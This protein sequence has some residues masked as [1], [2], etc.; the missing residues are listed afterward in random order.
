MHIKAR[1]PSGIYY[2]I[3]TLLGYADDKEGATVTG[4]DI[5]DEPR[6]PHRGLQ[7]DLARNFMP[8][9][10]VMRV[11][12]LMGQYKLN[13]LHLHLANDEGWRIDIPDIPELTQVQSSRFAW[14]KGRVCFAVISGTFHAIN[15]PT[16]SKAESFSEHGWRRYDIKKVT[17]M[18]T[19]TCERYDQTTTRR[20]GCS[21]V[22]SQIYKKQHFIC[23]NLNSAF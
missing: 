13:K 8:K 6:F 3:H 2:G 10:D 5:T 11:L 17:N 18:P 1:D 22:P 16:G 14:P 4:L 19:R 23:W 20:K 21:I 15:I 9:E 12:D 7:L